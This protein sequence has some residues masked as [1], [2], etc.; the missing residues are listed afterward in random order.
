MI[1]LT[2]YYGKIK[3]TDPTEGQIPDELRK[4]LGDSFI[5]QLRKSMQA[6]WDDSYRARSWSEYRGRHGICSECGTPKTVPQVWHGTVPP[7]PQC[8]QG[9][10]QARWI[11][12]DLSHQW[13]DEPATPWTYPGP[14]PVIPPRSPRQPRPRTPGQGSPPPP[15]EAQ[16]PEPAAPTVSPEPLERD[17]PKT[18]PFTF[19]E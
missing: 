6:D 15:I 7:V 5:D 10:D 2:P 11:Q 4:E 1:K 16:P 12:N 18:R 9:C 3:M 14:A 19:P 17:L 13:W 8:P